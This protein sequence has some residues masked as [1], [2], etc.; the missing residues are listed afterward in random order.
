MT[1]TPVQEATRQDQ[2]G[3]AASAHDTHLPLPTGRATSQVGTVGERI[4][5]RSGSGPGG[6]RPIKAGLPL[7]SDQPRVRRQPGAAA[8]Q[9]DPEFERPSPSRSTAS[10]SRAL[11]MRAPVTPGA[12]RWPGFVSDA[13]TADVWSRIRGRAV[14][15]PP[16]AAGGKVRV[17]GVAGPA[18]SRACLTLV[19]A[20]QRPPDPGVSAGTARRRGTIGGAPPA[21]YVGGAVGDHYAGAA[22]AAFITTLAWSATKVASMDIGRGRRKEALSKVPAVQSVAWRRRSSRRR[23][24]GRQGPKMGSSRTPPAQ[25]GDHPLACSAYVRWAG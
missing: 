6:R 16:P 20:R 24:R 18:G 25:P 12:S 14:P 23:W 21:A 17:D 7:G 13:V 22:A 8:R 5:A 4:L 1:R 15:Q 9:R 2:A 19:V 11:V 3:R 10:S